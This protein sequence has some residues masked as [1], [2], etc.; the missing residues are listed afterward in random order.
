MIAAYI[1]GENQSR[2]AIAMTAPVET[3]SARV[4]GQTIAMTTPVDVVV[5]RDTL[6]MRFFMPSAFT[7]DSLPV[8]LNPAVR[9]VTVP[10]HLVAVRRYSG[11]SDARD[12]EEQA[13][14]LRDALKNSA[15]HENGQPRAYFYN[16]PWT[17]PILRRN[18]VV[19]DV[20]R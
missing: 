10:E 4:S 18:E 9:I 3:Q 17:L 6:T 13:A 16:P 5:Q 12:L 19:I 8:P 1:F 7:R 15:W 11:L 20:R 2:T 14:L